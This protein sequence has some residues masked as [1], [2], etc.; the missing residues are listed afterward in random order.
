[1]IY[2]YGPSWTCIYGLQLETFM[3]LNTWPTVRDLHALW[4]TWV[5]GLQLGTIMNLR[6]LISILDPNQPIVTKIIWS[7]WWILNLKDWYV[8]EY[9][10]SVCRLHANMEDRHKNTRIIFSVCI[11]FKSTL[12]ENHFASICLRKPFGLKII[13]DVG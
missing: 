13:K 9:N 11:F 7:K 2:S 10:R 1:M 4:S 6:I 5:H 12:S 3:E 8:Y